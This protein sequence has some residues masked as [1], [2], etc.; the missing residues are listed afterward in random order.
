M[1]RNGSKRKVRFA[2]A[3]LGHIA[4]AAVLPGFQ[5]VQNAELVALISGDADKLNVL[6]ERYGIRHAGSY[7]QFEDCLRES[8]ADAVYVAVPNDRHR[9]FT[10]RAAHCNVHVLCEKPMGV[11]SEECAEMIT[12]CTDKEVK[13]MVAY[14][15]HF[16]AANLRAIELAKSGK[17]GELRLFDSVFSM[18]VRPGNIRVQKEHGGGSLYD[19]GI[20]CINAARYIFQDE[21]TEVF[22]WEGTNGDSRFQEVDE[23]MSVMLRFPN[24]RLASFTCSFNG[25]DLQYYTVMGTKGSLRVEPAYDYAVDLKHELCLGGKSTTRRFGK[26]D[27]FAAELTYFADCILKNRD[28][29]PDGWEGLQDVTIIEAIYK[30]AKCGTPVKVQA[31]QRNKPRA[32][33]AQEI[34]KPAVEEPELIGVQAP[35][36]D[37]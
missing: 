2:V 34:T 36:R 4:Q 19:I 31:F 16:E 35:T 9:E 14:R 17:L 18:Q 24:E 29:E 7:E 8:K 21:P 6:V 22:A 28:P 23:M 25:P 1:A 10:L 5:N 27:Q 15:L 26:R 32:S 3:G 37:T 20:Y 13:L 11:T 12:A 33:K 30:S